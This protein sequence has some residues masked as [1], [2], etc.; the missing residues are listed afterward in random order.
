[1]QSPGPTLWRDRS[2]LLYWLGRSI[3]LFGTQITVVVLP[4]LVFQRT[5]SAL[6]TSLLGV[7]EVL[8]YLVFGLLAGALADRLDRK[9]LM[10][11]SDLINAA[12][13]ASI[14]LAN[15]LGVL[16]LP[17]IYAV[18]LLSA[19]AFVWFDVA[20]FGALPALVGRAR[21]VAAN[22]L[23]GSS[24]I[25]VETVG[26]AL[27]GVLAATVGAAFA[28]TGDAVSYL[29]SAVALL[30]VRRSFNNVRSHDLPAA[31]A[32]GLRPALRRI[33]ADI[34]A[35]LHFLWQHRLVRALTLLG[36]GVSFT[37]GA[38]SSL[39]VVYA[40]RALGLAATDAR[41]GLIFT[42]GSVGAILA[43]AL[44]PRLH[45]LLPPGW[46]SLGGMAA[47]LLFSVVLALVPGFSA[48]LVIYALWIAFTT[49][50]QINGTVLR[51]R[52][53]P[54]Q[55]LSRTNAAAR[56]IA[57]GGAPVGALLGGG[58]AELIPIRETYLVM[59][60]GVAISALL[61]WFSPLRD[62]NALHDVIAEPAEPVAQPEQG[63]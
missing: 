34:R 62:R 14:P 7:L 3:S 29:L 11:G 57:W 54:E 17:H 60:I 42:A 20:N 58:L 61:G 50:V 56:M 6:L 18:A 30:L 24:T 13:L 35:G 40:V 22:S 59:T 47:M 63:Q 8:P 31:G 2:F 55:L 39:I 53:I 45:R 25:T 28:L 49:L 43:S 46:I 32:G 4:I 16:S 21:L 51:Q 48:A 27:A 37:S 19:C 26:A 36:F 23:I 10:I 5:R 12:L 9:R 1:M 52:V 33:L 41:I 15:A 38:I 44:L